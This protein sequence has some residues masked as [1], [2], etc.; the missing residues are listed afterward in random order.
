MDF[1]YVT[2]N[3]RIVIPS[4]LRRKLGIKPGTRV[5][6]IEHENE[7]L[8]QPMTK[9]YIR[10]MRGMLKSASSVGAELL[11]ER[12]KDKAREEVKQEKQGAPRRKY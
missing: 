11:N 12:R 2:A 8:L 1:A 9:E 3:G 5:C 4:R 6:F 7:I 10:N